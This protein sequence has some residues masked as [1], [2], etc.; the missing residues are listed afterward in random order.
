MRV[1][2]I[3]QPTPTKAWSSSAI[4]QS[5]NLRQHRLGAA[6]LSSNQATYAKTG[7]KQIYYKT[8]KQ[9]LPTQAWNSSAI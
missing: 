6:L 7:V 3:K 4:K 1:R 9:P 5:S 8:T 2:A